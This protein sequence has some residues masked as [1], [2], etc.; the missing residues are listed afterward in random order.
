MNAP[1]SA[2]Y[3]THTRRCGHAIGTD[4]Q[5]VQAA[6]DAGFKVLGF[7]DHIPFIDVHN[8]TDRMDIGELHDYLASIQSLKARYADRIDIKVGFEAEYYPEYNAHYEALLSQCDYLILGQH[9]Q[10]LNVLGYD[11]YSSDADVERYVEQ[12][13]AGMKTGYFAF[14]AHPDYFMMGRSSFSAAC[15]HAA[16]RIAQVALETN[17]PLELNL[18]GF[19]HGKRWIDGDLAYAYPYRPFWEILAQYPIRVVSSYDAHAPLHLHKTDFYALS[20]D[21]LAGLALNFEDDYR[22]P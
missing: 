13:C 6:I 7:S 22:L 12:V 11:E 4:E 18:N 14:L 5:Y 17:T 1:F 9:Y 16:H 10:I 3:H 19:R 2:N 8:K 21:I 15:A 20:R